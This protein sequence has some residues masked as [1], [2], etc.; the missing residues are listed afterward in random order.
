ML[1]G[2]FKST[3]SGTI[4]YS[5]RQQGTAKSWYWRGKL[6]YAPKSMWAM[7]ATGGGSTMYPGRY[8]A[9]MKSGYLYD[10]SHAD[11]SL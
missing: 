10:V 1:R 9:L 2:F 11:G 4:G 5:T 8:I 6:G 3:T 7:S